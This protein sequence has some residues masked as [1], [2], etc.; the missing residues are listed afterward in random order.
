MDTPQF[1]P[2]PPTPAG[3]GRNNTKV[4]AIVAAVL[5]AV[6]AGVTAF[7]VLGGDDEPEPI[8][9]PSAPASPS[10]S[11]SPVPSILEFSNPEPIQLLDGAPAVP[12]P[13]AILVSGVATTVGDVNV[14]LSDLSHEY[15]D[16]LDLLLVCP[17][18][19][20]V[21]LMAD[22]GGPDDVV[23][24]DLTFDDE[25]VAFHGDEGPIVPTT[26]PIT[27]ADGSGDCCGFQ[28]PPPAPPAPYGGLL[29]VFDGTD[30]NGSW[31]L[32]AFDDTGGDVGR[33]DGGWTIQI[34]EPGAIGPTPTP[35]TGATGG[36]GT[37]VALQDDFSDP[38]SGW[39]EFDG[40][41]QSTAYVD[42]AYQVLVQQP[43]RIAGSVLDDELA[44]LGDA[45]IVVAAT[46]MTD[47]SGLFYGVACRVLDPDTYYSFHLSTDGAYQIA[48]QD[49]A[50]RPAFLD[51]GSSGAIVPGV[52]TNRIEV[53][54]VGGDAGGEAFLALIVNGVTVAEV[55]DPVGL[56]GTGGVGLNIGTE[57]NTPAT[58]AFDDLLVER[59]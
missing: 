45:R 28:G 2:A 8:A 7:L 44:D 18:G 49:G 26:R 25:A 12:Y 47:V 32:Y 15:P 57:E 54:C 9:S 58:V 43:F 11:E 37:D 38:A 33:I 35:A 50:D 23:D 20:S 41:D 31:N 27:G 1:P 46:A 10:P 51:S 48:R 34:S 5:V 36:T 39:S 40:P 13:S 4:I 42:G 19:E 56:S 52:A 17:T 16:D 53:T 29:A 55:V 22:A 14:L 6:A 59:L 30:P 21:V 3:A 24:L